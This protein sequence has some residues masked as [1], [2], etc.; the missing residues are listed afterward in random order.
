MNLTSEN[1]R[2]LHFLML[3]HAKEYYE[4][5]KMMLSGDFEA[6]NKGVL[7]ETKIVEE[8]FDFVEAL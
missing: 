2:D 7:A 4:A 6:F 5:H 3:D 8:L 1:K